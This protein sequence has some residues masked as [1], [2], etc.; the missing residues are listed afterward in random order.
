MCVLKYLSFLHRENIWNAPCRFL[1][2]LHVVISP[3]QGQNCLFSVTSHR[4]CAF[5]HL[6]SHCCLWPRATVRFHGINVWHC[7]LVDSCGTC[8]SL[9]HLFY[10]TL[11]HSVPYRPFKWQ[12]FIPFHDWVYATFAGLADTEKNTL[13]SVWV[14]RGLCF[15]VIVYSAV[16]G[17]FLDH[18]LII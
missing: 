12:K 10:L 14:I 2:W 3:V 4:W 17:E 6:S 9:F 13:I 11:C 5:L 7:T 1:K 8:P 16:I 18:M 15:S